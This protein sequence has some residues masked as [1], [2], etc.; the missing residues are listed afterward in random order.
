MIKSKSGK[1]V[2]EIFCSG[3]V[4]CQLDITE[5]LF[6][7]VLHALTSSRI[8]DTSN[9]ATVKPTNIGPV[10]YQQMGNLTL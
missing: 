8:Q 2:R 1:N 9:L 7:D 3:A 4:L 5:T 6:L 10:K